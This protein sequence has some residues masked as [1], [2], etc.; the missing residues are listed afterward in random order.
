[1]EE[2]QVLVGKLKS[3]DTSYFR[4]IDLGILML[5]C[6]TQSRHHSIAGVKLNTSDK[7]EAY[8]ADG[9]FYGRLIEDHYYYTDSIDFLILS[10]TDMGGTQ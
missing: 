10:L 4:P 2:L 1:M 5:S 6:R 8:V 3:C 9:Q 7:F